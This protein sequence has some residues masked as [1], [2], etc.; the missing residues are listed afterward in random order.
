MI[1]SPARRSGRRVINM[2]S[3]PWPRPLHSSERCA[4]LVAANVCQPASR[5]A[6][7]SVRAWTS[8]RE[9]LSTIAVSRGWRPVSIAT[10]EGSVTL[11]VDQQR[12]YSTPRA[13]KASSTGVFARPPTTLSVSA[14]CVSEVINNTVGGVELGVCTLGSLTAHK[15]GS[16]SRDCSSKR[17]CKARPAQSPMGI[18]NQCQR[19]ET[20]DSSKG[21]RC[22]RS[23]SPGERKIT[24]SSGEDPLRRSSSGQP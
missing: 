18:R 6:S 17:T 14:R 1:V 16:P 24:D 12:S 7:A 13:A 11:V 19:V 8:K 21:S 22:L 5:N 15:A 4:A 20:P 10:C 2:R 3:K 23:G 9:S